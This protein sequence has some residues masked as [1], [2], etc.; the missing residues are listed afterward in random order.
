MPQNQI[1]VEDLRDL[2]NKGEAKEPLIFLES[3]MNG[4]DPR[5][6]SPLYELIEEI[7]NFTDGNISK[8]DWNEIYDLV[9]KDYK[10]HTVSLNESMNASKTLAEYLYPKRKQVDIVDGT[11]SSGSSAAPLSEEE[12]ELFKEKFNDEF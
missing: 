7:D 11:N 5:R 3:V 10:Y 12:I 9:R 6:I 1:S 8:S 2:I 4:Q